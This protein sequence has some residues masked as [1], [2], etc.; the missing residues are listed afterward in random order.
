M[1]WKLDVVLD[2]WNNIKEIEHNIDTDDLNQA[3]INDNRVIAYVPRI[4]HNLQE[5]SVV[6]IRKERYVKDLSRIRYISD[7]KVINK[8]YI[9]N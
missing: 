3:Y 2:L 9:D 8:K 4:A 6:I 7:L 1:I 5:H